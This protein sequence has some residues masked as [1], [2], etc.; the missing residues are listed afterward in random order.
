MKATT[1]FALTVLSASPALAHSADLPHA[2][3][4]ASVWP[5]LIAC[6]G[7]AIAA[8][9]YIG[10]RIRRQARLTDDESLPTA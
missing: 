8:F 2:H 3:A 1:F 4:D 7:I 6:V 10:G 5:V 9:I